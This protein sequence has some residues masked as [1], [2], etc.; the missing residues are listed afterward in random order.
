LRFKRLDLNLLMALDAMLSER[1]VT[2]AAR[3]LFLSQSA[4]SGALARLRAHFHDELL[5]SVGRRMILTP[6]AQSIVEPVRR[7]MLQ[8][9]TTVGS[10]ARFDPETA[11]RKFT[12]SASDYVT[13]VLL[14]GL[15]VEV[16][17]SAP[18]VILEFV[19]SLENPAGPLEA[20]DI[21]LLITP[22]IFASPGHPSELLFEDEHVVVG[23]SGNPRLAEPLSADTF[24]ELGHVVVRFARARAPAFADMQ[25]AKLPGQRRI[26]TIAAS[27][28]SVPRMVVGTHRIAVM[29]RRLAQM[30]AKTLPLAVHVLPFDFPPLREMIQSHSVRLPDEGLGWLKQLLHRQAAMI[31]PPMV[32]IHSSQRRVGPE[33]A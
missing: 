7:L 6:F 31:D 33:R 13:E 30:Y 26:E 9:E 2:A 4:T 22:D 16:A 12:I 1:S 25:I 8:I 19:P 28:T 27:F 3:R 29:H 32:Q 24:F 23:W 10:G 11:T 20:G 14:A 17:K 5:V 21:D 15:V 18:G